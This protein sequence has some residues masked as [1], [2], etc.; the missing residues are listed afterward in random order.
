MATPDRQNRRVNLDW[1]HKGFKTRQ[2]MRTENVAPRS[3]TGLDPLL[4]SK[5]ASQERASIWAAPSD[6]GLGSESASIWSRVLS[7][8]DFATPAVTASLSTK[9]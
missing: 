2:S 5:G 4:G 3:S 1:S 9:G 7:E 8:G 6:S